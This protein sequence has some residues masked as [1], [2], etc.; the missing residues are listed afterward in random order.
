MKYVMM[1]GRLGTMKKLIPIIFP[2]FMV[3]KT[4][5]DHAKFMLMKD[6]KMLDVAPV[7]AGNYNITSGKCYGE[8]ETLGLKAAKRDEEIILSYDYTH[9]I[10]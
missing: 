1:Q 9:G 7:S 10:V 3:H 4:V 8:S 6:H 2:E 5:A